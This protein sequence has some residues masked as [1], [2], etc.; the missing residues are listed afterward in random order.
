MPKTAAKARP[1]SVGSRK[2]S[3]ELVLRALYEWQVG[4]ADLAALRAHAETADEY[5]EVNTGLFVELLEGIIEHTADLDAALAPHL[6][7]RVEELSPIEHGCLL[8]GAFELVNTLNVPYKVAINEAVNLAKAYGG[9]DGHKFVN[10]VLDKLAKVT[11]Q[12]EIEASRR[13]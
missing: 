2:L 11:R 6:D 8:I 1:R 9:T 3:R 10:G 13:D 5:A 4:G 12:T 7:R